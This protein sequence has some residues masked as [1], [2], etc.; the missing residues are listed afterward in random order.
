MHINQEDRTDHGGTQ[1]LETVQY[2]I[3]YR[4]KLLWHLNKHLQAP[5]KHSDKCTKAVPRI[6]HKKK[7]DAMLHSHII[8]YAL[9]TVKIEVT[10]SICV[11]VCTDIFMVHQYFYGIAL[12]LRYVGLV[13]Q[14]FLSDT[15]TGTGM[16]TIP[17]IRFY[18]GISA[19]SIRGYISRLLS[20]LRVSHI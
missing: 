17:S 18:T 8:L 4:G 14:I 7:T 5:V 16:T 1:I 12:F 3:K 9:H 19:N 10:W 11:N 6:R 15:N 20:S 2:F 13:V